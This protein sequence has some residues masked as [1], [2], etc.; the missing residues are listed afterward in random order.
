MKIAIFRE[1][2]KTVKKHKIN[3][4]FS[5]YTLVI[6]YLTVSSL[7]T[8]CFLFLLSYQNY[9]ENGKRSHNA[10]LY[11]KKNLLH[12]I[13]QSA[14]SYSEAFE[15]LTTTT[16]YF[17]DLLFMSMT[18][19]TKLILCIPFLCWIAV[20]LNILKTQ[21]Q[22]YK[23]AQPKVN[24]KSKNQL[25]TIIK[26]YKK[27][28][29]GFM[30]T[31]F[32]CFAIFAISLFEENNIKEICTKGG[33]AASSLENYKPAVLGKF[34]DGQITKQNA[35]N[36]MLNHLGEVTIQVKRSYNLSL[37]FSLS[38]AILSFISSILAVG[39]VVNSHRFFRIIKESDINIDQEYI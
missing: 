13:G 15:K 39:V 5:S 37:V 3:I 28:R 18:T 8:F 9:M 35:L 25:E 23:L 17:I 2:K 33:N 19:Q 11:Y 31:T 36:E 16:Q 30:I 24:S 4:L 7:F 6:G 21:N 1:K 38:L 22:I 29:N 14:T 12:D 26:T 34:T 32:V 27:L 10:F 20:I